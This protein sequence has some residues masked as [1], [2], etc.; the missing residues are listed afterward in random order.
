MVTGPGLQLQVL[1]TGMIPRQETVTIAL[2]LYVRIPKGLIGQVVPSLHLAKLK[3]AVNA[4]MLPSG[5]KA[6]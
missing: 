6:L 3:L 4:A 1:E 5:K 2:N